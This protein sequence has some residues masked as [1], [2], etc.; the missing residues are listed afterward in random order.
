MSA[1]TQALQLIDSM[2]KDKLKAL[3]KDLISVNSALAEKILREQS[4]EL[5]PSVLEAAK[6][7]ILS[8]LSLDCEDLAEDE[9]SSYFGS[10]YEYPWERLC[11]LV[12]ETID[13]EVKQLLTTHHPEAAWELVNFVLEQEIDNEY[14]LSYEVPSNCYSLFKQIFESSSEFAPILFKDCLR[15]LDEGK[16][17]LSALFQYDGVGTV[18]NNEMLNQLETRLLQNWEND[19]RQWDEGSETKASAPSSLSDLML[20]YKEL[21]K[22]DKYDD[23]TDRYESVFDD[24]LSD[25]ISDARRAGRTERL[26][27]LHERAFKKDQN[28]NRDHDY[29]EM[30]E[31]LEKV[32]NTASAAQYMKKYLLLQEHFPAFE[33]IQKLKLWSEDLQEWE[34]IKQ[35][36]LE[37][38]DG[39][40]S[41]WLGTWSAKDRAQFFIMEAMYEELWAL[42]VKAKYMEIREFFSALAQNNTD[43]TI[44]LMVKLLTNTEAPTGDHAFYKAM[45]QDFL[46]LKELDDGNGATQNVLQEWRTNFSRRRLL[47]D[48][49]SVHGIF[50]K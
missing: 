33:K 34:Q 24:I 37:K 48:N 3:L 43:R 35:K 12:I 46:F 22:W 14:D 11:N 19:R 5:D 45:V 41:F 21:G 28:Q 8:V 27:E 42:A 18:F 44:D 16:I 9:G 23:L 1:I 4:K 29:L 39:P 26:I 38:P 49:L 47:W 20:F 15:M 7:R 25:A 31:S 2:P 40:Q 36:L 10:H 50:R 6:D 17:S 30:A 13:D 32:G